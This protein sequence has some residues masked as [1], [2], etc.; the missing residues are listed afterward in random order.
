[1][2]AAALMFPLSGCALGFNYQECTKDADCPTVAGQKL[3]CTSEGLCVAGTPA[4]QLCTRTHPQQPAPGA[5]PI[6]TIMRLSLTSGADT[7]LLQAVQLGV[8]E[9]NSFVGAGQRPVA[10]HICDSGRS[11]ED[12]SKALRVLLNE[13]KVA[14]VVGPSTS[15]E[16]LSV[17]KVA[18]DGQVP[19]V[20]PSATAASLMD[21]QQKDYVYKIAPSDNQQGPVL[22]RLVK[23]RSGS[24]A[25]VA[26][27]YVDDAY[28]N[29]L[30]GAVS[31]AL[32]GSPELVQSFKEGNTASINAAINAVKAKGSSLT[33]VIIIANPDAPEFMRQLESLPKPMMGTG[34]VHIYMTDGAKNDSLLI[35]ARNN[36]PAWTAHLGRLSGTSPTVEGNAYKVFESAFRGKFGQSPT[37]DAFAPYA[38]DSFFALAVAL[39]AG[40]S[41]PEVAAGLRRITGNA[42]PSAVGMSDYLKAV[43][44]IAKG[45]SFPLNGVTGTIRFKDGS[46]E[47]G[48]FEEWSISPADTSKFQSRLL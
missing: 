12:A 1:M 19:L 29:G 17:A 16:V 40:Q 46:R 42:A 20:S 21:L 34:G 7:F 28:G 10:L 41:G 38:Y 13:R 44:R 18:G 35:M 27:V 32:P 6:G 30:Q 3:S 22:A 45:E 43:G 5:V 11:P 47:G 26:L 9:V 15:R 36:L 24:S 25:K 23:E 4:N 2:F 33:D 14:A 48:L 8:D 31:V 39:G 37:S